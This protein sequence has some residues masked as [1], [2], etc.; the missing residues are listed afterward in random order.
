[1]KPEFW[2]QAWRDGR[3][4]FH[5]DAA[6]P[7]L[8]EHASRFAKGTVLVPLCGA[9]HDLGWLVENG[10]QAVGVE[11][12]PIAIAELSERYQ[13]QRTADRGP[14]QVVE[15]GGITVLQ[16]DFFALEP[17]HVGPLGFIWDRAALVALHP[18]QREHYV[19]LQKRLLGNAGGLLLNVLD[20]DRSKLDGPPWAV[21]RE[22]V[23]ALWGPLTL[24]DATVSPAEGRFAEVLDTME[25]L[26]YAMP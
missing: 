9:T 16:G 11:L 20:Y 15:G 3:R 26:L 24:L 8:I 6:H 5:K 19:A 1:M 10:Y 14:F 22:D 23:A 13:L 21:S 4:G 12:S 18:T 2:L 7:D 25:R 17:S